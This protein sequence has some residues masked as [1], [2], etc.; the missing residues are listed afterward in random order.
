M[1]PSTPSTGE[2]SDAFLPDLLTDERVRD[3]VLAARLAAIRRESATVSPSP[4]ARRVAKASVSHGCVALCHVAWY[5]S[6]ISA[7]GWLRPEEAKDGTSRY[8]Q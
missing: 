1:S 2:E 3:K 5:R 4:C 8:R 7:P 6:A